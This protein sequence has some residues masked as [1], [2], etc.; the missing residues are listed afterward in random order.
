MRFI[1]M[2]KYKF[3]NAVCLSVIS[4]GIQSCSPFDS[5]GEGTSDNTPAGVEDPPVE[6]IQLQQRIDAATK[7]ATTNENCSLSVL[8]EGFYW[9]I[10][11]QDG[12][13]FSSSVEGTNT[14]TATQTIAIASASK[15][16]YST[17]VLQKIGSLREGDVP[18][19]NF[20]SGYVYSL[21]GAEHE[22]VCKITETVGEC[23][24]EVK[25]SDSAVDNFFY[26][27]GH[28][29]YHATNTM[30]LG[31][32][33]AAELTTEINSQLGT[34]DFLYLQTNLAGGVNTSANQYA[35]FLRHM[36]RGEY[37]VASHLGDQKG[38]ASAACTVGAVLSPAPKDEE[39]NY[40]LGHWVEDDPVVGDHAFS[41]AGALGFYPWIDAAKK[42]YGIFARRAD[43]TGGQ[44]GTKSLYCGRLIRKA[45]I[46]GSADF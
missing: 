43:S 3:L 17:Y 33:K 35:E 14:P 26:S 18:F 24:A 27:A 9:E 31:N 12:M 45:W 28:F 7:I 22:A 39:W 19:L 10:G 29:Q 1:I 4:L 21:A 11:D 6:E 20:T 8:P 38:C 41:S 37:L 16:I 15:W 25:L 23:A 34:Q 46:T 44:Q 36:L 32:L 40:S 13:S 42:W 2:K 5:N 30:G